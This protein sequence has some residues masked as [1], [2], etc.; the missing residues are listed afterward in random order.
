MAGVVCDHC[1]APNP[2]KSRFCRRCG[3]PLADPLV[4]STTRLSP[5]ME[6]W[7]KLSLQMTRKE[8]RSL[9]GEPLRIEA[10]QSV[11]RWTYEYECAK[12]SGGRCRGEV[13]ISADSRVVSWREPEWE[14]LEA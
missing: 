13:E 9:L 12:E 7:R 10:V 2:A 3:K 5:L 14:K 4:R 11:E 8:L 1:D 6:K